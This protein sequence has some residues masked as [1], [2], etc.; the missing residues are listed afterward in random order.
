MASLVPKDGL[1]NEIQ[2]TKIFAN[3]IEKA[4]KLE[5]YLQSKLP[6]CVYNRD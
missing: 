3:K 4:I 6:N 2:K 1:R 5:R